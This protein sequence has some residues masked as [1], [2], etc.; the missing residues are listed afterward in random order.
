MKSIF[1]F[2]VVTIVL[3]TIFSACVRD[4]QYIDESYWL[5]KERGQVVHSDPYCQYY[6]VQT[7]FGYTILRSFSSYKPYEGTVVYGDFSNYG[8]RD[9]YNRSNGEILLQKLKNTGYHTLR[10]RM[11]S[12]IIVIKAFYGQASLNK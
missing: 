8:I 4:R 7:D 9:F 5:N 6:V 11:Q 3:V 12:I 10:P 2:S 1:T